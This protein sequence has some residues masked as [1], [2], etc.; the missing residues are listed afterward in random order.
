MT[1]L[2]YIIIGVGIPVLTVFGI[3]YVVDKLDP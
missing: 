2:L 1:I 3:F